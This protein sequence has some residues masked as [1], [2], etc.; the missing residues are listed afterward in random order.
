MSADGARYVPAAGRASLTRYYDRVLAATMR[1]SRWRPALVGAVADGL[2]SG[3]LVVDVGAGTGSVAIALAAAE[4]R[5]E[6]VAIDGDPEAQALARAKPGAE[7]VQW[8]EGL[9]ERLPLADASADRV[10]MSLLLHHLQ[11][12]GKR[13]ALRE[14]WRV[15][16]PGGRLHV[17]DWG[18]PAG[19]G[20]RLAFLVLQLIDGFPN[21]SDHAAGRLPDYLAE[22]G[23]TDVARAARLRTGWGTLELLRARPLP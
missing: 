2:P 3:G 20:M 18:R 14:A 13:A 12:D 9:A 21:T 15:L 6:V 19:P 4:P 17:A 1:E 8:R 23:F 7:R 16:R 11:P 10:V 5:A 22:A